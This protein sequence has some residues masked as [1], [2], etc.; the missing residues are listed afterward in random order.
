MSAFEKTG[1]KIRK[2]LLNKYLIVLVSYAVFVA[3]FDEHS[4]IH[5]WES[6]QKINRMEEELKFYQE[7]IKATKQKK[8]ELQS[9]DENLE[10][11][12]R[13]HYYMKKKSEDI[14]IIKE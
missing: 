6:H 2:I 4:L 5:R 14:F 7:E 8:N 9:S 11:F 12:A 13:E 10:K 3:F 1:K